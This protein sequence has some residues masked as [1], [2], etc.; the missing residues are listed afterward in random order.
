MIDGGIV[1]GYLTAYLLKGGKR[2]AD[3]TFDALLD[4][5]VQRVEQRL[6][7]RPINTLNQSPGDARTE[8]LV[9]ARIED[10][11]QADPSF[12][13]DLANLIEQLDQRGGQQFV[14]QVY[15]ETSVQSFGSGPAVGRD[16]IYAPTPDP[17]DISDAPAWVKLLAVVGT[18]ACLAA[19]GLFGYTLFTDNPDFDDP[20]FGEVPAG[21]ARAAVIFF[22]GFILLAIAS[23]GRALSKRPTRHPW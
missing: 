2:L 21:I 20:S 13:A 18:A 3:S 9:Q 12:A 15:A 19:F 17:S 6:G 5:L 8:G 23:F 1:V 4:R 22:V 14:N 7:P 16:L 10:A 11:M